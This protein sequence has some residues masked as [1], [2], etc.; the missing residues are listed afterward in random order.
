MNIFNENAVNFMNHNNFSTKAFTNKINGLMNYNKCAN[1]YADYNYLAQRNYELSIREMKL[2]WPNFH[3]DLSEFFGFPLYYCASQ[4]CRETYLSP[5]GVL[6]LV[7]SCISS[8][9]C[10]IVDI[11]VHDGWHEAAVDQVV[12]FA[13][14]GSRKS[15][16]IA[17]LEYPF[18]EL[19]KEMNEEFRNEEIKE[20]IKFA[21]KSCNAANK[22][23]IQ[24]CAENGTISIED[25]K[26]RF[27]D[28]KRNIS[29]ADEFIGSLKHETRFTYKNGTIRG[30]EKIM[31]L[32]GGHALLIMLKVRF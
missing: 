16:C 15:A 27:L 31:A 8:A 22:I 12:G 18:I 2:L 20:K 32:N 29:I 7:C 3:E 9:L 28:I 25:L 11:T 10:G 30:L 1:E 13:P 19:E 21:K 23:K 4:I 6:P 24:E 17:K 14:S 26:Q 5:L